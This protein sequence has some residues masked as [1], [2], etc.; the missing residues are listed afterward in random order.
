MVTSSEVDGS[1]AMSSLG[2][3][4]RAMEIITRCAMPPLISWG[5][6]FHRFSASTSPTSLRSSTA[7]AFIAPIAGAPVAIEVAFQRLEHVLADGVEGIQGSLGLLEDG[8]DFAAQE[9]PQLA[10]LRPQEGDV[11][12]L[13]RDAVPPPWRRMNGARAGSRGFP[14]S[15]A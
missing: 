13:H 7:I 3:A 10:P 14:S 2:L 1:S 15:Q 5:C 9:T 12:L 4:H 6:R 8:G 11:A